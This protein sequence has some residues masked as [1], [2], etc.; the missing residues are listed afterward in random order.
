MNAVFLSLGGNQGHREQYLCRA[1]REIEETI[2]SIKKRSSLYETAP[3]GSE[4][5]SYFLNMVIL[6][7]TTL[8]A[9]AVLEQICSIENHLDRKRS[10]ERNADRS[11]DIDILL[12]NDEVIETEKMII[13]HPRMHLRNFVLVPFSEIEGGIMHPKLHRSFM[14]LAMD[15]EDRLEVRKLSS[16]LDCGESRFE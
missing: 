15:C 5:A 14:E 9:A 13:P 3:W 7:R 8:T 2:G 10:M 12:F 4:S 16:V 11:I 1:L 6:L